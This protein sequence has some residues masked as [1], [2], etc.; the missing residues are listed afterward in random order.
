MGKWSLRA[1]NVRVRVMGYEIVV[2]DMRYMTI[3]TGGRVGGGSPGGG[4]GGGSGS[5][6]NGDGSGSGSV[7][8]TSTNSTGTGTLT[9]KRKAI[10]LK[11]KDEDD[12]DVVPSGKRRLLGGGGD[13]GSGNA[14]VEGE[15]VYIG[16]YTLTIPSSSSF[17]FSLFY[18]H[19]VLR[20]FNIRHAM[21]SLSAHH[22]N[23]CR[24][25]KK[26]NPHQS[27]CRR[28]R[29]RRPSLARFPLAAV[30]VLRPMYSHREVVAVR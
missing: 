12:E 8:T 22:R 4:G 7:T 21:R 17:I 30:A 16:R 14:I 11:E 23:F 29:D 24:R 5:S 26:K 9:S 6:N 15:V 27:T 19:T 2:P 13:G 10:G 25:P 28:F 18:S 3:K 20:H 1:V